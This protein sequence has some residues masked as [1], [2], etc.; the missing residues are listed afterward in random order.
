MYL[1]SDIHLNK[2]QKRDFLQEVPSLAHVVAVLA[3]L[4]YPMLSDYRK[5]SFFLILLKK[6]GF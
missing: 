1:G 4:H 2:N 3:L 5:L 6:E